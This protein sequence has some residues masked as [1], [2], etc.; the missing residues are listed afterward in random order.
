[1]TDLGA[2]APIGTENHLAVAATC[3][4]TVVLRELVGLPLLGG[5][6]TNLDFGLDSHHVVLVLEDGKKSVPD[7]HH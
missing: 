1:M 7:F 3:L 4:I 2:F 5:A 6:G